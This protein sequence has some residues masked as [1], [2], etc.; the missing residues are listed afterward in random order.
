MKIRVNVPN[1]AYILNGTVTKLLKRV[2]RNGTNNNYDL[3]EI[4]CDDWHQIRLVYFNG[5][6]AIPEEIENNKVVIWKNEEINK[7]YNDISIDI[8]NVK[9]ALQKLFDE[10]T[11]FDMQKFITDMQEK[12][13]IKANEIMVKQ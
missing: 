3:V 5:I 13:D 6:I 2:R 8:H 9:I 11:T 1:G 7:S 12:L 4:E 10:V